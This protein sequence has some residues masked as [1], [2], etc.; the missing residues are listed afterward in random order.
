MFNKNVSHKPP[1]THTK[2]YIY[3]SVALLLV[4]AMA[5]AVIQESMPASTRLT[6][7]VA[8]YTIAAAA[9]AASAITALAVTSEGTAQRKYT[10]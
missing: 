6:T 10:L 8:P 3:A 9:A 2:R 4:A 7:G 5:Q 1:Y